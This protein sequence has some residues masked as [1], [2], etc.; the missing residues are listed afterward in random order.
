[1]HRESRGCLRTGRMGAKSWSI[2]HTRYGT[3]ALR[4][5]SLIGK[6]RR[7]CPSWVGA[8]AC[9]RQYLV[10]TVVGGGMS[11]DWTGYCGQAAGPRG[12]RATPCLPR[13]HRVLPPHLEEVS[14]S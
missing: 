4:F 13:C 6:P 14:L 3:R 1:M 2:G 11:V 7:D 9:P 12:D 8:V 5:G 10:V